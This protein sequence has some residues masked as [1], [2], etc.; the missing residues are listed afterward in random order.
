MAV[1]RRAAV[2]LLPTRLERVEEAQAQGDRQ[3][4]LL[5]RIRAQ[6]WAA[7][8]LQLHSQAELRD[9]QP[10]DLVGLMQVR[11]V[12]FPHRQTVSAERADILTK[13]VALE[14]RIRVLVAVAVR[15]TVLAAGPILQA[16]ERAAL[17][18]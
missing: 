7:Q 9:T 3:R 14:R 4:T 2:L 11:A 18:R 15:L 1:F 13:P 10:E 6:A 8:D 5:L 12:S 16:A 17:A